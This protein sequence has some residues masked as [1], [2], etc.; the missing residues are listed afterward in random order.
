MST[1]VWAKRSVVAAVCVGVAMVA[2]P[3]WAEQSAG[4]SY[5]TGQLEFDVSVTAFINGRP[6]Q[7]R[8]E[9]GDAQATKARLS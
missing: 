4:D 1:G 9:M 8:L 5:G 7:Q 6:G 2:T 3:S